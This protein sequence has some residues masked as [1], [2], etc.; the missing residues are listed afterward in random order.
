MIAKF[1][2]D[3]IF[4][5]LENI[6]ICGQV[7]DGEINQYSIV[8]FD[9]IKV[10]IYKMEIFS[11]PCYQPGSASP[12]HSNN[13]N[14]TSKTIKRATKGYYIG[15]YLNSEIIGSDKDWIMKKFG[16]KRTGKFIDVID[17]QEIRINKLKLIGI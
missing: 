7:M 5:I 8:I 2:I 6:I 11:Y 17:A 4:N 13:T 16:Y 3:G 14:N 9:E 12:V 10:P 15:I 1:K